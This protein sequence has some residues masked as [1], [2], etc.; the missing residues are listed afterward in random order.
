MCTACPA[1]VPYSHLR[2]RYSLRAAHPRAVD[3]EYLRAGNTWSDITLSGFCSV[4]LQTQQ[5]FN[6]GPSLVCIIQ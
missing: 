1:G 4:V 3:I 2:R 5:I 6:S